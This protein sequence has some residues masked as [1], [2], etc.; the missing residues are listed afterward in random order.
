MVW[1]C[2]DYSWRYFYW[3]W[4]LIETFLYLLENKNTMKTIV[5]SLGGSLIVPKSVDTNFLKNFKRTIENYIKKDYRFVIYCGGGKLAR[6]YQEVASKIIKLSDENLDWLGIHATRL[7]ANLL[8]ILFKDN[9]EQII[10]NDP[11][12][13][14]KFDKK[15]LIA[16]GWKPG[17]STDYDTV[18]LAKNLKIKII[19]NMSNVDYVYDKD[20]TKFKDAKKIEKIS[21]QNYR[22]ISGSKW[23]AGLNLPFDPVAAKEAQRSKIKVIVIGKSLKNFENLL[24]N[25]K[26]NG[27]M[28]K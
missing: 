4:Q 24:N 23:K 22:K 20:P 5:L 9:A 6:L 11:A 13:K 15:I 14:I 7:N 1:N 21:W 27:T 10:I 25:K 3:Y 18:L 8:K 28:I 19:V 26:F 2:F 17:W 16:A 12:K